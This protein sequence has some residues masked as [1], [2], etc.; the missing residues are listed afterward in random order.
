MR[1][2]QTWQLDSGDFSQVDESEL[3]TEGYGELHS[4]FISCKPGVY[5]AILQYET[6]VDMDNVWSISAKKPSLDGILS[7]TCMLYQG[8]N[9]AETYVWLTESTDTLYVKVKYLQDSQMTVQGM[10]LQETN[11]GRRMLLVILCTVFAIWDISLWKKKQAKVCSNETEQR[12]IT[13]CLAGV[14]IAASVPLL[15]FYEIAGADTIYHLL[16]IEGIKD[17]LLSGQFPVRIQPN[18]LQGYGY[19][20][21]IFYC[22][23]YLYIPALLRIMGF[24]VGAAYLIYKIL[25]NIGTVAL[26]YYSFSKMFK[27]KWTGVLGSMLYSLNIY[28][29]LCL[30]LKDHLGQYTAMMFL[31]FLAYGIWRLLEEDTKS[32]AYKRNWIVLTIGATAIV[33]C[34]ILTCEL[35]VLFCIIIG[36]IFAKQIFRKQTLCQIGKAILFILGINLWFFIPFLDYM[37]TQQ[38]NIT[39]EHVYTRTIQGH[40]SLLPQLLGVFALSGGSDKDVSGGMTGEI[41]FTIGAA[42]LVVLLYFLYLWIRGDVKTKQL[43]ALGIL[44]IVTLYMATAIFPWDA[45]QKLGGFGAKLISALQYPT[46]MLEMAA[47]LLTILGC[48]CFLIGRKLKGRTDFY[49]YVG[50]VLVTTLLVT[51]MFY[52]TLLSASNFYKLYDEHA[53]GNA[54][55]SGKEYLPVGTNEDLLLAGR[56]ITSDGITAQNFA[57]DALHIKIDC[58]NETSSEGYVELPLLY[59]KGYD[60]INSPA[61]T[62]AKLTQ[63]DNNVVRILL[64]VGFDGILEVDFVSPWYWR[65]AE[66]ISVLTF[67]GFAILLYSNIKMRKRKAQ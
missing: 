37:F 15:T 10:S 48:G 66:V 59:Y 64:P 21:G 35:A 4:R 56:V 36:I 55:L 42:L 17:G 28:R 22:D 31:P 34:H 16:R 7:N 5:K 9:R 19:A 47:L 43:K 63:G 14:A 13:F 54:Y 33:Q 50:S 60:I 52:S 65:V 27:D 20:T 25:V 49:V 46:R 44:S 26:S 38:L 18:W 67:I 51:G 58:T 24:P 40:G 8:E 61:G 41:P 39:G 62:E 6:N 23:T 32:V 30:Y 53:M 45:I 29:L 11:L 2:N 12:M 1:T 57:K 3:T